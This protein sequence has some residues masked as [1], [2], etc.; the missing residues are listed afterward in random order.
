M[1]GSDPLDS[2]GVIDDESSYHS[3]STG[4]DGWGLVAEHDGASALIGTVLT[5]EAGTEYTK[6][7]LSDAADVAYK[8]LYLDGT[9][10]KLAE[11]GLLERT[12][13]DGKAATFRVDPDSPVYDAAVAFDDAV[14]GQ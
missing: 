8:T 10:E 11:I 7:E 3:D 14:T 1:A 2:M 4:S 6:T 9:V 12:N 13:H 5:L